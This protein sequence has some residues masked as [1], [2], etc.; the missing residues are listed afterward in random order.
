MSCRIW[1]CGVVWCVQRRDLGAVGGACEVRR[2]DLQRR[3][4]ARD[5]A[6]VVC[7]CVWRVEVGVGWALVAR[8]WQR[9]RGYIKRGC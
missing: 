1:A 6:I 2:S 7:V 5:Q 3:V 4:V 8:H 9:L